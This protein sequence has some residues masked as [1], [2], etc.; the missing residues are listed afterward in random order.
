M[1]ADK[2]SL[3][4]QT[5]DAVMRSAVSFCARSLN[6]QRIQKSVWQAERPAQLE[7]QHGWQASTAGR[8]AQLVGQHGWHV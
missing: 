5:S 1:M 3:C 2:I 4:M 8:Q 7:G 6:W